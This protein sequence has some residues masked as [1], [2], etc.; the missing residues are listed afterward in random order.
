MRDS[1][2]PEAWICAGVIRDL[3]RSERYGDG[4]APSRVRDVEVVFLDPT[5]LSRDNDDRVT[6]KAG[7]DL[8]GASGRRRT[9]T[10]PVAARLRPAGA[11]AG[12]A[13]CAGSVVRDSRWKARSGAL[14]EGSTPVCWPGGWT[15]RYAEHV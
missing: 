5:D 6:P 9:S 7:D 8:A 4:G 12:R 2:L 15:G 13:C 11:V 3:V 14:V 10:A 1:G